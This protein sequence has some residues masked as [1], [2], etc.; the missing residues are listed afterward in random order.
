MQAIDNM[1]ASFVNPAFIKFCRAKVII[2]WLNLVKN[3][4]RVVPK[5]WIP[6]GDYYAAKLSARTPSNGGGCFGQMSEH[7]VLKNVREILRVMIGGNGSIY[8]LLK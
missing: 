5:R 2:A 6:I 3:S 8:F 7:Q 4:L 1:K